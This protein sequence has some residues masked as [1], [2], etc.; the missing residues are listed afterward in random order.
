MEGGG[1][2]ERWRIENSLAHESI[3]HGCV[4]LRCG[5]VPINCALRCG[6]LPISQTRRLS[7]TAGA[8]PPLS[9]KEGFSLLQCPSYAESPLS[10][11][12]RALVYW[13]L[14]GIGKG[15]DVLDG[16]GDGVAGLEVTNA[17]R[18]SA[19]DNVTGF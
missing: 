13:L 16:D 15:A 9:E 7:P 6:V 14:D 3:L 18:G 2:R 8:V 1:P 17:G 5:V 19:V 11:G 10:F 12:R 4:R